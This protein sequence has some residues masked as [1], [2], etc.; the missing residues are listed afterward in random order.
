M[1]EGKKKITLKKKTFGDKLCF[2]AYLKCA[3]LK[4]ADR[5]I[6]VCNTELE[7]QRR[8]FD[9]KRIYFCLLN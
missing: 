9:E 8:G 6:H 2:F 7:F 5:R 3:V 1:G 4:T